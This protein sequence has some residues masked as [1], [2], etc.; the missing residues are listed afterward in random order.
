MSK[1]IKLKKG[2]DINLVGAA[3]MKVSVAPRSATYALTPDDY[4]GIVPKMLV[5]E[6]DAV[7]AG[8]PL[9]FDKNRADLLF[10]S[11][12]SGT[13]KAIVRGEKRKIMH[14][15]VEA[16]KEQEYESFKIP[17]LDSS[18]REDVVSL[19]LSSGLWSYIIQ[20]PYGIIADN[21]YQPK[22]IFVSGFDSAPLAGDLNKIL[23]GEQ[24]SLQK[25]FDVL[26]RLTDGQVHLS[27]RQGNE[28][29][30]ASITGVEK[31]YFDGPHPAGNVGVQI[32]HIDPINKG[33][34]VWTLTAQ[35][36]AFIGRLFLTGHVDLRK[37]VVVCGSE[38][39]NPSYVDILSGATV[40]SIVAAT[41]LKP[42]KDGDSVRIISGN[43]LSGTKVAQDG[44]ITC[45][46]NQIT[47]IPEGDKYELFGWARAR[48]GL[49]SV[50]RAY[51]SWL[52]PKHKYDLDTNIHGGVRPFVVSSLYDRYLPM[53]IYVVYL[54]KAIL[55]GDIEKMENLGI[56][57]VIEEDLALCEFVDPSKIEIQSIVRQ[58]INMM[59][60]ELN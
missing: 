60:K 1:V 18:T 5:K 28:G 8:T 50:S 44:Y 43:V 27:M 54:I 17:S 31:H 48:F 21:R 38:V 46:T 36:V 52:C 29:V 16:D 40:E 12:V 41:G 34:M 53:D 24:K 2:L 30:F 57:E 9:F 10:T 58:G 47:V 19:L 39:V 45:Y 11:P 32:N 3:P 33:E 14:V 55:A 22:S 15:V 4:E 49:F 7:K 35:S 6:G 37:R 25:G 23:E 42:Q 13:V 56:Y 20:R 51:F 26:A 59:I